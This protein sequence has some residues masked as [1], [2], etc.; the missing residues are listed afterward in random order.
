METVAIIAALLGL[1]E[2]LIP[3]LTE[4]AA[5]GVI[6]KAKQ[7]EIRRRYEELSG[8]LD[9]AFGGEHWKVRPDPEPETPGTVV[10]NKSAKSAKST[11]DAQDCSD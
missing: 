10:K 7:D 6:T 8:D 2:K 4:L 11:D 5:G 9:A 3:K 1:V